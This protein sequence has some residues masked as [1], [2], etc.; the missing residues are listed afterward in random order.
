VPNPL[1][2]RT[3]PYLFGDR[4]SLADFAI[5]GANKA[6]FNREPVC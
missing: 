1:K 3:R 5:Y 6:H 2:L 4:P